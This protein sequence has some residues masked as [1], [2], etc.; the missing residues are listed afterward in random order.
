MRLNPKKNAIIKSM[1]Y[2]GG[3]AMLI[4]YILAKIFFDI[5]H[6]NVKVS[7]HSFDTISEEA[8]E[9][10]FWA[11]IIETLLF[12]YAIIELISSISNNRILVG[13]LSAFSFGVWHLFDINY[14]LF[15]FGIGLY[16]SHVY[17]ATKNQFNVSVANTTII[18][19]HFILNLRIFTLNHIF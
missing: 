12:Q 8:Y 9:T 14:F 13:L 1:I 17:L 5:F 16:F 7:Y 4:H 18:F 3:I 6:P 15:A 11:P 10:L 2:Y 19:I